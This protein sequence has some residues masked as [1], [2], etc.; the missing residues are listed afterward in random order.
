MGNLLMTIGI[1]NPVDQNYADIDFVQ[2]DVD[3]TGRVTSRAYFG[4]TTGADPVGLVT[5]FNDVPSAV[6]EPSG[7]VLLI[8]GMAFIAPKLRK[9]YRRTF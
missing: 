7:V 2:W 3:T 6:P 1:S 5:G 8:T 4:S 9:L